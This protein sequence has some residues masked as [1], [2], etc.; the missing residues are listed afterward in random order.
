MLLLL[1]A[2]RRMAGEE[3]A[4]TGARLKLCGPDTFA[5]YAGARTVRAN[6]DGPCLV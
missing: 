3:P 4:A 6:D 2:M 5:P 1:A